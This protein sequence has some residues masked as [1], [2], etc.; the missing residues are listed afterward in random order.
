LREISSPKA[1][2]CKAVFQLG[3]APPFQSYYTPKDID[4]KKS[5]FEKLFFF[6]ITVYPP[7]LGLQSPNLEE[8]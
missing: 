6:V 3:H 8:T 2:L 7:K 4:V 5:L 1:L